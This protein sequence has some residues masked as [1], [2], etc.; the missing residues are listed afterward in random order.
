M[1][2]SPK[3]LDSWQQRTHTQTLLGPDMDLAPNPLGSALRPH[4][5]PF[6]VR[7]R[8][9]LNPLGPDMEPT[10]YPIGSALR[11]KPNPFRLRIGKG[12]HPNPFGLDPDP[13][14]NPA[15]V[16]AKG[17][18]GY[19]SLNTTWRSVNPS[20]TWLKGNPSIEFPL[21]IAIIILLLIIKILIFTP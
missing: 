3:P 14:P 20:A 18:S 12:S 8:K 2:P 5:N 6:R 17:L 16:M 1:D 4:L 13:K 10:P 11:P 19:G 15:W 9:D 7:T 21:L